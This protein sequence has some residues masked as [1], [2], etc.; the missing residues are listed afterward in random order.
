M[1]LRKT[2]LLLPVVFVPCASLWGGD[3]GRPTGEG[4]EQVGKVSFSISCRAEAQTTFN[5]AV[6]WLHSFEYEEAQKAFREVAAQDPQC[7]MAHW[8]L[9]MSLYHELWEHPSA[10]DLTE[11]RAELAK[12][13]ETGPKTPRE[14]EYLDAAAAFYQDSDHD[15]GKMDYQARATAYCEAMGRL[16]AHYPDDVEAGAFDALSLIASE[17]PDDHTLANR[18]QAITIL[19]KLF[20]QEPDHPGVAHYL[21]H[22]ADVPQLAPL[23]LEAA[24]R[25]AK[26]APSSPHA[27]HMPSHIF[28]RLGLW[29]NSIASN[30]ASA[31]A[32]QTSMAIHMGGTSHAAHAMDFLDY[33]Y[34][35]IGRDSDARRMEEE[36][37]AIPGIKP[38]SLAFS[39]TKFEARYA[40]ETHDWK[41]AAGLTAPAGANLGVQAMAL[42]AAAM[43][44]ARSGDATAARQALDKFGALR[45]KMLADP[46]EYGAHPY[47]T[48]YDEASAWVA[49]AE[50]KKDEALRTLRAVADRDDAAGVDDLMMPAREMLGDLLL[51]LDSPVDAQLAYETALK[52]APNRFDGL[53]GA[54]KAAQLSG[55]LEAAKDYYARLEANCDHAGGE[56]AELQ[57]ARTFLTAKR[58]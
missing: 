24:R 10:D 13:K 38:E 15:S 17:P 4:S 39:V 31:S 36:V 32:A 7:A 12:A 29:Q 20:V 14:T 56:R 6:A 26:I 27:L 47:A 25:Y 58:G 21:I 49:L 9:A 53:Y 18:K 35:Q 43:G 33:A 3:G 50:G 46:H 45:T 1:R 55:H 16:Y 11:G 34:L 28:T 19:Q 22:A 23:G 2:L 48:E 40:I 52:E 42:W 51:A 57:E 41:R 44:A 37:K 8:G 54:A 5:Q 30:I